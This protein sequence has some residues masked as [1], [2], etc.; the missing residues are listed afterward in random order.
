MNE[1]NFNKKELIISAVTKSTV[2][3]GDNKF[4]K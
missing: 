4:H 3:L 2:K 1:N